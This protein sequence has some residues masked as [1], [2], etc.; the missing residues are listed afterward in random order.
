V[1]ARIRESAAR[2]RAELG[3]TVAR[4]LAVEAERMPEVYPLIRRVMIVASKRG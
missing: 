4:M 3:E 1:F 2:L